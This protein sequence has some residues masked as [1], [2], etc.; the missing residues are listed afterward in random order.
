[1]IYIPPPIYNNN[2]PTCSVE[3]CD[4]PTKTMGFCN[5]HYIRQRKFGDVN[6]SKVE[7]NM[8]EERKRRNYIDYE[9]NVGVITLTKGYISYIDIEDF[10][11]CSKFLWVANENNGQVRALKTDNGIVTYLSNFV[12]NFISDIDIDL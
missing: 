5:K 11:K 7:L 9:N 1:V 4:N 10:E 12:L 8:E 6:F 2:N 3:G